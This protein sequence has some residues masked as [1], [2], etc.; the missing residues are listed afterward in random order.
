MAGST[1]ASL[2][3]GSL[4][5]SMRLGMTELCSHDYLRT[6]PSFPSWWSCPDL[7]DMLL[8]E[9]GEETTDE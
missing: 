2:S 7:V 5:P 1:F 6:G 8:W 4:F 9:I 3:A